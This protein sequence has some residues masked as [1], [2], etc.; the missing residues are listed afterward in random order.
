MLSFSYSVTL[1]RIPVRSSILSIQSVDKM[2]FLGATTIHYILLEKLLPKKHGKFS[3]HDVTFQH[4]VRRHRRLH[5]DEL[6]QDGLS[7][8]RTPQR[9]LRPVRLPLHT[10]RLRKDLNPW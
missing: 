3:I 7:T 8:C 9:P 2:A 5:Q 4:L 1:V 6:E 10:V